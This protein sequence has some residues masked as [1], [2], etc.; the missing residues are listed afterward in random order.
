MKHARTTLFDRSYA[1]L[2]T[3][4][5]QRVDK[6][7]EKFLKHPYHPYAKGLGV[8]KLGGVYGTP[9]GQDVTAPA[10]WEM[11]ATSALLITFQ[12]STG[13]IVFRNCGQHKA[14]LQS[15]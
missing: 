2:T 9:M 1:N 15:P 13:I 10:V 8:H 11:H 4:E 6:A 7:L 14:V 3:Q 5:Q 12:F